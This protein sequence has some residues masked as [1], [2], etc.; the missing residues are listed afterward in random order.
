MFAGE[1]DCTYNFNWQTSY[2]CVQKTK[3]LLCRV[4]DGKMHYDLS[5]LTRYAGECTFYQKHH[6]TPMYFLTLADDVG[7]EEE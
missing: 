1:V 6:N 2:A 7:E 3:D 4:T 5:R